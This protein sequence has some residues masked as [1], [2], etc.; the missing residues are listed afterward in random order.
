MNLS[1]FLPFPFKAAPVLAC[2]ALAATG[3]PALGQSSSRE[4]ASI[5]VETANAPVIAEVDIAIIGGTSGAVAAAREA[6]GNGSRVFLVAPK[7]YLG[8]DICGTSRLWMPTQVPETADALEAA[9][10]SPVVQKK[11]SGPDLVIQSYSAD[12]PSSAKH[13]DSTSVPLLTDGIGKSASTQSVQFDGDVIITADLG[14]EQEIG[15]V[16][17]E[18]YQRPD[19]FEVAEI[20]F[21]LSSDGRTWVALPP[22]VNPLLD[23]GGFEGE[24]IRIAVEDIAPG[25]TARYVR[26]KVRKTPDVGRI[27]LAEFSVAGPAETSL[28]PEEFVLGLAPMRIKTLFDKTLMESGVQFLYGAFACSYLTD[29]KGDPAGILIA[30]KSGV[31]A[32]LAPVIIDASPQAYVA[33]MAGAVVSEDGAGGPQAASYV[34]IGGAAMTDPDRVDRISSPNVIVQSR[35]NQFPLRAYDFKTDNRVMGYPAAAALEQEARDRCWSFDSVA[36][37]EDPFTVPPMRIVSKSDSPAENPTTFQEGRLSAF[38]PKGLNRF[39]VLSGAADLERGLAGKLLE[40]PVDMLRLGRR[41]GSAA[42]RQARAATKPSPGGI[43]LHNP[44]AG[45]E[46]EGTQKREVCLGTPPPRFESFST[47]PLE[48]MSLPVWANY[49]V[50]VAG[51]GTAGAP[52]AVAAARQ[53]ARTLVIEYLHGMGGVGTVGLISKYYYGNIVGFTE[54]VDAGI[55]SFGPD[56]VNSGGWNVRWK[57]EWY[58]REV[59][60]AGGDI[61]FGAMVTGAVRQGDKVCGLVVSTAYGSGVVLAGCIVDS[62]GNAGVAAA[63][64]AECTIIDADSVAVQGSG[65]PPVD[66]GVR[67]TNTDYSFFDDTD[68]LDMQRA[69]IVGRRKYQNAFDLG[70]LIDT[71][72]RRRIVGDFMIDPLDIWNHRTYPDTVVIHRSNFDSHGFTTHPVFLL[73]P[74]DREAVFAEVPLRSLLPKG[75]DGILVTG[76][77][78]SAHRD[79]M[80][81]I[82]MQPGVQNQGYAAGVAAAMTARL[83]CKVRDLDIQALQEHL[84]EVGILPE[85]VIGQEDS[86]PIPVERVEEAVEK[87]ADEFEDLEVVLCRWDIAHPLVLQAYKKET[88]PER[89]LHFAHL[90]GIQDDPSGFNTL[91]KAIRN[92]DWDKGW[93]FTGM[94]QFGMSM[95]RFDSLLVALARAGGEKAIPLLAEKAAL[96]TEESEF[97]HFRA[98]AMACE[99]IGSPDAAGMLGGLLALPGVKGHV[100]PDLET[101]LANNPASSTDTSTRN[102]SLREIVLARALYRCGDPGGEGSRILEDYAKDLRGYYARHAKAV[103]EKGA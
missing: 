94:G 62:T 45:K 44:G 34:S 89:Q 24:P 85:R 79:A 8:E 73:K 12:Q 49:D 81:V 80:P 25:T 43:R 17:I 18:V 84:V 23:A 48:G 83:G 54:E 97:S 42:A 63:A 21:A 57:M 40:S 69:Y 14:S 55:S 50:V 31:Q 11:R 47:I 9:L 101:A 98:I 26:A 70:Q 46:T 86:F 41:I 66:L 72:E 19:D 53:G 33:Q 36:S 56:A 88:D 68:V 37:A 38:Q 82:R 51:G 29:E 93:R 76:L 96:L 32:V 74:P 58:R 59:R 39:W 6:A 4:T 91:E 2:V 28:E 78:V 95:S 52:A 15:S 75:L 10:V 60:K 65:L 1:A 16:A 3:L 27:L 30:N 61:W 90:L 35:D 20:L 13:P 22:A 71:R 77:A 64:G 67:Y 103:L 99:A 7:T 92:M 102:N 87:V 5:P 100:F